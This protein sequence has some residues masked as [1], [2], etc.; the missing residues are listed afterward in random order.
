MTNPS[1]PLL[2][3][4]NIRKSFGE[5]VVLKDVSFN[6]NKGEAVS[7]IGPSGSGKTTMLRCINALESIDGGKILIDGEPV[8]PKDKSIFKLREK[9]GFIF[10]RFNLFSHLTVMENITLAQKLVKK[11]NQQAAEEIANN[12]LKKVGLAEKSEA[13]PSQL[14]G[15]QQQ[16]VAIARA[17]AMDPELV[18]MDEITSALDP[19]LV[20]EVLEVVLELANEGMTMVIVTHEMNF[21][22]DVSD[23]IIFMDK[24]YVIEEGSP[25]KIFSNPENE[26]TKE[27]LNQVI[28]H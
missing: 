24:G 10:Q 8:N 9:V 4:K 27:F 23:R 26:R 28:N 14:S 13:Y 22:R 19:E 20:N 16:R 6:V 11:R 15:G 2:Q 7:I 1:I 12:L 17:L 18:L 5:N 21:A 3:A 25:E